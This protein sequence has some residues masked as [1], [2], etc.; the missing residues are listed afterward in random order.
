[1]QKCL[2]ALVRSR[3]AAITTLISGA[4]N[5]GRGCMALCCF[6]RPT[7]YKLPAVRLSKPGTLLYTLMPCIAGAELLLHDKSNPGRLW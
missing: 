3:T 4:A 2:E 1:M 6:D 7:P 5:G